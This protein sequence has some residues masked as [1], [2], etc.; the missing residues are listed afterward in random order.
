M[1]FDSASV[2]SCEPIFARLF[3]NQQGRFFMRK[4]IVLCG[5]F[6]MFL[7]GN[8]MAQNSSPDQ[9]GPPPNAASASP[10]QNTPPP[11]AAEAP[12]DKGAP[13]SGVSAG[14]HSSNRDLVISCKDEARL[15]GLRGVALRSA[16]DDCVSAQN[17]MLGARL[18]CAQKGRAQGVAAGDPIRA[19]VRSCVAQQH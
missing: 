12:A 2:V 16:I 7:G 19:F 15:K 8:A 14:R 5:V 13:A 1:A 6:A 18:R 9:A 3:S 4:T 10:D 17:P 11:A